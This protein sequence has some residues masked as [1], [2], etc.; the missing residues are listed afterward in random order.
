MTAECEGHIS[1]SIKVREQL[2]QLDE[3]KFVITLLIFLKNV[4][5]SDSKYSASLYEN[6]LYVSLSVTDFNCS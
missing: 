5:G 3:I 2:C 1:L 4:S 6:S